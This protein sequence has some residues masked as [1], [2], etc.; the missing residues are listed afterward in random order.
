MY[1]YIYSKREAPEMSADVSPCLESQG[2]HLVPFLSLL[3]L[4]LV[5]LLFLSSP[6]LSHSAYFPKY[7]A[8]SSVR[9]QAV[10]CA[11]C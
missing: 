5:L 7:S 9:D 8:A 6:V 4:G 11:S 1:I 3:F 2:C 10:L